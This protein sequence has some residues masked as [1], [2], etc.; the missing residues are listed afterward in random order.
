[1]LKVKRLRGADEFLVNHR[2]FLCGWRRRWAAWVYWGVAAREHELGGLVFAEV[3]LD[4]SGPDLF[5]G[6]WQVHLHQQFELFEILLLLLF[7]GH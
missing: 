7:R 4:K 5:P 1:M 6:A 2:L 3:A